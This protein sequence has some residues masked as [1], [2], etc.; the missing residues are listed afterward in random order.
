MFD[1]NNKYWLY[2]NSHIYY[3]TK[4][5]QAIL[6]NTETGAR[7]E[8][9]DKHILVL[10]QLL[11]KKKNMGVICCTGKLL[12]ETPYKEFVITFCQKG[13]GDVVDVSLMPK[14]PIQMLP[15]LNLQ[16]DINKLPK[17]DIGKDLLHYLLEL[18]IYL[19][20]NCKQNCLNCND[21]FRQ[22]LC[23]MKSEREQ[24][25]EILDI[26]TLKYIIQQIQ[27]GAVNKLNLL[28]GNI[29][30]YP[31]YSELLELLVNFDGHVHIWNHCA[32]FNN[33][34]II[35]HTFHY[36]V[37]V[38][39][40][41]KSKSLDTCVNL[42]KNNNAKFHFYITSIEEYEKAE[43]LI[44][45]YEINDYTIHPI[46][47]G[48]N[49]A[50]FKEYIYSKREDLYQ[51]KLPFRRIFSHQK[52]NTFFFGT[53]TILP[54]S[55]VYANINTSELGNI[56]YSTLLDVIEK[57]MRENTAWRKIRDT[58]PCN[59]CIY[60]YICPSPSNYELVIGKSNLCHI[61]P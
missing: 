46:Y 23:C 54:N 4:D 43:N 30:E 40:P 33:K 14:K 57:E 18:N 49:H 39:F 48:K 28:G 60:Q 36:E 37:I 16:S 24:C 12:S 17:E 9:E 11:Q 5:A 20:N 41:I 44:D 32:N 31:Y 56:R 6:Y 7:I 35:F 38:T 10:L 22:I 2:I 25:E 29:F 51:I 53:L 45:K 13:M 61:M 21:I 27:Y 26:N 1:I 42:C 19:H 58:S 47:T 3:C 50:F 15:V 34:D 8:T 55:K 52:M 59:K